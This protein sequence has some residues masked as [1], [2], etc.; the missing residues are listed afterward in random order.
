M[1]FFKALPKEV[2]ESAMVD[3]CMVLPLSV[4]ALLTVVIF[5]MGMKSAST[6]RWPSCAPTSTTGAR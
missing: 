4:P 6:Y 1:G 3:G 2:E 5:G